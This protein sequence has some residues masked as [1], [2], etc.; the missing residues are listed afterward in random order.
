MNIAFLLRLW[1]VYGGGET[2]TISLANEMVKRGHS[3]T[4]FYFKNSNAGGVGYIN[5]SIKAVKI[6]NIEC[7][8]YHYNSNDNI[9]IAIFFK[10]FY[11][12]DSFDFLIN[13]WWPVAFLSPLRDIFKAKIVSVHHTALY[14]RSLIE[15]GHLKSI[16]KRIFLP[17]YRLREKERQLSVID[18]LLIYSDKV[19]F[20]SPLFQN[21]YIQLR[22][23]KSIEKID[24]CYNP[25][26]FNDFISTK[27]YG[28]KRKEVL[29][30]GRLLESNK[31]ILKLLTIWKIIQLDKGLSDWSLLIVGEG[32][33][34]L[35]YMNFV[36]KNNIPNVHFE[37]QQYP[38]P[39]YRR[40]SIFAMTSAFEGFGMSIIE[41][42]QSGVVPIVMNSFLSVHDTI[43]N[44][45]NG[46]LIPYGNIT[47]FA[48][49][50]KSLMK[51]DLRRNRLALKG[52]DT[53]KRFKIE[54][55]VDRWENILR[56]MN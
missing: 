38:V 51:D 41:A 7:D 49:S 34:K 39:Y 52:L 30:V 14:T 27:E 16:L 12:I 10:T 19:L 17:I 3:I 21:Q 42:Q 35:S 54:T 5:P 11:Q 26:T 44:D 32:K 28:E 18:N 29:F 20:L 43:D 31:K 6:S 24:W 4:I 1:P 48:N 45:I 9:K 56:G 53:C 47:M 40:A 37:G 23:P 50:L 25:L 2:V 22:K 8:E 13:Q 55:V 46:I 15:G 33:D 36:N